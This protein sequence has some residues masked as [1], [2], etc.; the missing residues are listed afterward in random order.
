MMKSKNLIIPFI[1]ILLALSLS[2]CVPGSTGT[3]H[4]ASTETTAEHPSVPDFSTPEASSE[5]DTTEAETEGYVVNEGSPLSTLPR[6][7]AGVCTAYWDMENGAEILLFRADSSEGYEQY[8]TELEQSGFSLYTENEIVGNLYS[9]WTND[10]V[11]VTMMYLPALQNVRILAEPAS[12]GLPSLESDNL[13][14][15]AG[16]QNSIIQLGT[17][18]D[19]DTRNGMCYIYQLCD[20]SFIIVDSGDG[21]TSISDNIYN[22]LKKYAPDPDNIVVAAWFITHVHG[23]HTSAFHLFAQSYSDEITVEQFIYNYPPERVFVKTGEPLEKISQTAAA[24]AMFE[25]ARIIEAHPGQE[26]YIRDAYVEMIYTLDLYNRETIDFMNN[27]SLV[28]S[29]TFDDTKIMQTGDCGPVASP[30]ITNLYGEYLDCDILQ[31]AHHGYEGATQLLN[32]LFAAEVILYPS[33]DDQVY[34]RNWDKRHL[35]FHEIEHCYVANNIGTRIP[36]PFNP[37]TVETWPLFE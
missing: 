35:P 2:A 8:L 12:I 11:H 6:Y 27:S 16:I 4:T 28:F 1:C 26:F 19:G 22:T 23:D 14:T 13:Y 32:Q 17:D 20:G 29:I 37:D 15:D 10:I 9:T 18:F 31:V 3:D 36:L 5:A 21:Q 25:G 34:R 33:T 30:I 24:C 7:T